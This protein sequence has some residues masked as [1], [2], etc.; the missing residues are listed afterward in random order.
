[1]VFCSTTILIVCGVPCEEDSANFIDCGDCC[2]FDC[3]WRLMWILLFVE[4]ATYDFDCLWGLLVTANFIV[5]GGWC[6]FYCLWRMMWLALIAC[7]GCCEFYCLWRLMWILLFVETAV[8]WLF[9]EAAAIFIDVGRE[10]MVFLWS[11]RFLIL[12]RTWLS[13]RTL[14]FIKTTTFCSDGV[15]T[16]GDRNKRYRE[17]EIYSRFY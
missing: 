1:M 3:L 14:S 10:W 9:V 6:E 11:E 15:L 5:C 12:F 17:G 2:D 7:G 13:L 8:T 4:V 16:P